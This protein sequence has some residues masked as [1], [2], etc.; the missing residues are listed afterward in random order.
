MIAGSYEATAVPAPRVDCTNPDAPAPAPPAPPVVPPAPA[1]GAPVPKP[2]TPPPR[3]TW[4]AE[5]GRRGVCDVGMSKRTEVL[6]CPEA[7]VVSAMRSHDTDRTR[8]LGRRALSFI[9]SPPRTAVNPGLPCR[10]PSSHHAVEWCE[11]H[12]LHSLLSGSPEQSSF[13]A[14]SARER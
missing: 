12:R 5:E 9:A 11:C 1:P 8:N 6:V 7:V 4:C 2:P 10:R 13:P 3:V 14:G